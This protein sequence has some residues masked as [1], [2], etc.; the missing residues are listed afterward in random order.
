MSRKIKFA[1]VGLG[2]I[3]KRHAAVIQQCDSAELAGVCDVLSPEMLNWN[4]KEIQFFTSIEL[5]LQSGLEID[6]VNICTPNGLHALQA[7]KVLESGRHVVVEKPMALHKAD[8]ENVIHKA[9]QHSRLVFTVMQ[10]RYSPPVK[11]LKQIVEQ[12][13]LGEVFFVQMN[14]FWN[15]DER[16]YKSGCWHGTTDLDGGVLFT[17]FSHFI[18]IMYWLFGDVCNFKGNFRNFAH[19]H[20]TAFE[21]TGS[22]SF[23]FIKGGSAN[24]NYTTAIWDR[25]LESS[26]TVIGLNGSVKIS[27]QYM[28]RVEFCHIKDYTMPELEKINPPNDYGGYKGSASNHEAVINNVIKT[29][30]GESGIATNALEGM[31]VVEIIEKIYQVRGPGENIR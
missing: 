15:R 21:D 24:L 29:I 8:A 28:D 31:K 11:W 23:D 1:I 9:L 16:Y 26:I 7:I 13:V 20:N 10:N 22:V 18:D 5:M 3:G 2:Q 14:C 17:Q 12:G 30:Q 25:N 6:V 4:N 27:G 19:Q